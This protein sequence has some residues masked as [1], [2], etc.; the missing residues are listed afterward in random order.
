MTARISV[1]RA[2][3]LSAI[4]LVGMWFG[5]NTGRPL[6]LIFT[7]GGT[8]NIVTF[9]FG[10]WVGSMIGGSGWEDTVSS[11][12]QRS[13]SAAAAWIRIALALTAGLLAVL[14]IADS[15]AVVAGIMLGTAL[16]TYL[17]ARETRY[18]YVIAALLLGA[19]AGT[20]ISAAGGGKTVE[21]TVRMLS[22][23]GLE[24]VIASSQNGDLRHY[25]LGRDREEALLIGVIAGYMFV[26]F[27][28]MLTCFAL[29]LLG[30][31]IAAFDRNASGKKKRR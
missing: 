14:R 23:D 3:R 19:F 22:E 27:I 15:S 25:Y 4:T 1:M 6:D 12:R 24:A 17:L 30:I 9:L 11:F 21:R 5:E 20:A 28:I 13:G 2:L 8:I 29:G 10:A 16:M 26:G 31:S 7:G 18:R